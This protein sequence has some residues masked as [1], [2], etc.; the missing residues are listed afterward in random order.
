LGPPSPATRKIW[1]A[2]LPD[3]AP[4][5]QA[6]R[7]TFPA[8]PGGRRATLADIPERSFTIAAAFPEAGS[9]SRDQGQLPRAP[10][11]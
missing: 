4:T 11:L 6:P 3:A 8:S 1:Q 2:A 5:F 9:L 10:N 7:P